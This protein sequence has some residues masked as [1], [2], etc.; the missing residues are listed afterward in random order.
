MIQGLSVL[1]L[2]FP[3]IYR[4]RLTCP[5]LLV[6]PGGDD[7]AARQLV[8]GVQPPE[9]VR[10]LEVDTA[11]SHPLV[12]VAGRRQ[13]TVLVLRGVVQQPTLAHFT[14][15]TLARPAHKNLTFIRKEL[16]KVNIVEFAGPALRLVCKY[17][18]FKARHFG[19]QCPRAQ[20]VCF[21]LF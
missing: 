4:K 3:N 14:S 9:V 1:R 11:L 7:V 2:I 19:F 20:S 6:V 10:Q 8:V 16:K 18:V 5:Y 17:C 15:A 13:Q 21:Y 12:T